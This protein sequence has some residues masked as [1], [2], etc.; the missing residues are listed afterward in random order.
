MNN[1]LFF[2]VE[3]N[4]TEDADKIIVSQII[5]ETPLTFSAKVEDLVWMKDISYIE[6]VTELTDKLGY[7]P[8]NIPKL[9]TPELKIRLQ[10][11]AEDLSLIRKTKT[12]RLDI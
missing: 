1:I 9:L 8:Q 5:K 3:D 10:H 7:E 11:E 6:A 12:N 4:M 2:P